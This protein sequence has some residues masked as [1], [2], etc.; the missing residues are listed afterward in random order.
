MHRTDTAP[1]SAAD[2]LNALP[3][4]ARAAVERRRWSRRT[5]PGTD[6]IASVERRSSSTPLSCAQRGLW[7]TYRIDARAWAYN[8]AG[9]VRLE[10]PLDVDALRWSLDAVVQRH[11]V[12][13]TAI[14]LVG[15]EPMS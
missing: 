9:G 5:E 6:T 12:L 11:D 14:V 2:I 8:I 1:R 4:A 13:R 10:G 7:L 15:D 3:P